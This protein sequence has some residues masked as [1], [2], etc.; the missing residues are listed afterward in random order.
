VPGNADAAGLTLNDTTA[1]STL[2]ISAAGAGTSLGGMVVNG[3]L[4]SLATKNVD[5]AGPMLAT[6]TL[7]K[8]AFRNASGVITLSGAGTSV[9]ITLAPA[10]DLAIGSASPITS[11]KTGDWLDTDADARRDSIIAPSVTT[12]STKSAFQADVTADTIG[13]LSAG[14]ALGGSEIRTGGSIGS[15][16]VGAA[17]DSTI[18]AGVRPDVTTLPDSLAQFA[19]PDA[20]IKSITLKGKTAAFSNTRI[21]AP[22]IGKASLGAA[23]V[24]GSTAGGDRYGLAGDRI[25]SVSGSTSASGPYRLARLQDAGTPVDVDDFAI[26]VL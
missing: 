17:A 22:S 18:F 8:L 2:T 5:L 24:G 15:V 3:A 23:N 10:Q 9:T 19:N 6:G 13:K 16:V 26:I 21:A 1:G 4:R 12:I 7:P 14:G 25:S 11:L 20:S